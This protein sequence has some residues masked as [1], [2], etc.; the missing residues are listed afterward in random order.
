MTAEIVELHPTGGQAD[1]TIRRTVQ[2]LMKGKGV[3]VDQIARAAHMS[4]ATFYN[5][6]GGRGAQGAF[7]AGEVADIARFLGVEVSQLYD[8][9][10]GTFVP[11]GPPDG[12]TPG[13]TS[14]ADINR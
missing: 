10:G 13:T 7:K 2:A 6:M 8:G 1:D 12:G 3:T 14:V 9:L 5:H 11:P 4:R